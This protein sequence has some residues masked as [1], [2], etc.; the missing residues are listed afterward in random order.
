MSEAAIPSHQVDGW[1][2]HLE[3]PGDSDFMRRRGMELLGQELHDSGHTPL[4]CE[5]EPLVQPSDRRGDITISLAAETASG[6]EAVMAELGYKVIHSHPASI[7]IT[8]VPEFDSA[9]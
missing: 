4:D 3:R 1:V 6:A 7:Q 8:R 2:F 5:F 9:A